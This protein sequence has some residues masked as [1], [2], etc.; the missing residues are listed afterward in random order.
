MESAP[1]AQ[2]TPE[3]RAA[4]AAVGACFLTI[5]LA[6]GTRFSL[7]AFLVPMQADLHLDRATVSLTGSLVLVGYGLGQP[8]AGNLCRRLPAH[9]VMIGSV[10]LMAASGLAVI[11]AHQAWQLYLF[12]GLLPGLGFAGATTVPGA[13]LLTRWFGSRL[14]LATGIISSGIPAGLALFVPAATAA[15][16]LFGWRGTYAA[17]GLLMAVIAV[18]ALAIFGRP[19]RS[20][21][22]SSRT[23]TPVPAAGR[24]PA[25]TSDVWL[26]AV[27]FFACG[28]T[29]QFVSLHLVPLAIDAGFSA[30]AAAVFLS[31]VTI[32]GVIGSVLSGPITDRGSPRVVLACLYLV[33]AVG[34]SLLVFV[35][36]GGWLVLVLFVS[37]FGPTWIANQAPGTRLVRDRFGNAAVGPLMGSLGFAHQIGG[38]LGMA[39]GGF[40]V[41]AFGSYGPAVMLAAALVLIGGSAQLRI[42][43][44]RTGPA[45]PSAAVS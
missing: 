34:L 24:R 17:L 42:Q 40:S 15:I 14:G 22:A 44:S 13:V 12:A 9:V 41:S 2:R 45:V 31:A 36:S 30:E 10:L 43:G 19:P 11:A 8:V 35:G 28:F 20:P 26:I 21:L 1:P 37:L 38:A 32:A 27:G 4:W 5:L 16:P 7:G 39:A 6:T 29:D 18:P 33:R 25:L 23:P 3:P